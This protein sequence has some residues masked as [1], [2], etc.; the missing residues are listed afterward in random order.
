MIE[1]ILKYSRVRDVKK[2]NRGTSKSAGIDFFIPTFDKK[3]IEDL[4]EK[5]PNYSTLRA[6]SYSY[7]YDET[8]K[9][10]LLAPHERLM[11]PSGIKLKGH[12]NVAINAHNKSG[13]GTKKGLDRLA[14]VVDEDYEGEIHISIVNTS[15]YIVEIC[16]GEKL[17]QWLETNINYS[18]LKETN[19]NDLFLNSNSERGDKGFGEGTGTK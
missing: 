1:K 19:V 2:P 7:Y 6:G 10:I 18:T 13:V 16:E 5:N 11:I 4:F 8:F 15:N 12:A 3:F 9:K 14:E 17:I